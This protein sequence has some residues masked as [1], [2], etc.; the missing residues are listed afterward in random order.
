MQ[1]LRCDYT[2][3]SRYSY[4]GV[5]IILSLVE[6]LWSDC[7]CSILF[8]HHFLGFWIY[9]VMTVLS[10]QAVINVSSSTFHCLQF[11]QFFP[12]KPTGFFNH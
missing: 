1:F 4:M 10:I 7:L 5:W 6:I 12:N 3:R 11:T 2:Q 8:V 9:P